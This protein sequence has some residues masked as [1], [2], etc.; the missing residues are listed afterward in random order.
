MHVISTSII[1]IA[2]TDVRVSITSAGLPQARFRMVS[3]PRKYEASAGA[4]V[5]L[6]PSFLSVLAWRSLAEH[7]A[8]SVVKGDPLVVVGKLRVR[9]WEQDGRT[10]IAVEVDA[11][12]VGHD[13]ARGVS[14]FTRARRPDLVADSRRDR[15]LEAGTPQEAPAL[16]AT[17]VGD[18]GRLH[19][20][21]PSGAQGPR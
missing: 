8:D 7:V 3:Q 15:Q 2:V 16:V 21:T 9:E 20:H 11:Q 17:R 1:G 18:H 13:L 5:D 4:Y 19:L 10:R 12:A 14:R 6:D